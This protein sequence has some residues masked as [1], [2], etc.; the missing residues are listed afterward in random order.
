MISEDEAM[1]K[2]EIPIVF[3]TNIKYTTYCYVAIYSLIKNIK[4]DYFYHIY[5]FETDLGDENKQ[6]LESLS[7]Q[8]V[9]VECMNVSEYTSKV[10]LQGSLYLSIETYYRL[11]IPCVLPQYEKIL[12]L[13]SDM[14]ILS[15]VAELYECDL[16]G[17]AIGAVKDELCHSLEY[18]AQTLGNLDC[19]KTFN[20]GVL[21]IDTARFEA[22]K[23]REKCLALLAEDYQREERKLILADQDALNI[24]LYE[25]YCVLD[26]KWNYQPQY[27]CR[28]EEIFEEALED[29]ISA[30]EAAYIMH[31]ASAY[32]P[33]TYPEL[34]QSD[35]FWHYAQETP[36]YMKI[37]TME[38]TNVDRARFYFKDYQFPYGKIPGQSKV[39]LY[40]AGKVGETFY[41]QLRISDYAQLVLWVD[42]DW[43]NKNRMYGVEAVEKVVEVEYDYLIIAIESESIAGQIKDKLLELGVPSDKIVWEEY[44][45]KRR[46]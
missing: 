31:F 39:A 7:C 10:Q 5:I 20:A 36:I 3:A 34:P 42:S 41:H 19:R 18:H 38:L 16:Q 13:D 28:T 6:M 43:Q 9:K 2:P 8:N 15:D 29:Y 30:Q 25:N 17:Y 21:L 26:K 27:L 35:V 4:S 11:F 1:K 33:W 12:Y 40:A 45:K 46:H 44:R 37:L 23:I 22:E 24:V 32:K 14:C